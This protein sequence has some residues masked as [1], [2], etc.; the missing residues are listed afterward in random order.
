M[1]ISKRIII[2]LIAVLLL[3]IAFFISSN[4]NLPLKNINKRLKFSE[5]LLQQQEKHLNNSIQEIALYLKESDLNIQ[6]LLIKKNKEEFT[7]LIYIND[8]LKFWSKNTAPINE[9]AVK[10]ISRQGQLLKLKNGWYEAFY[11]EV[12]SLNKRKKIIG[13]FL[14]KSEYSYENKYLL[15]DFNP[16]L[17]IPKAFELLTYNQKNTYPLKSIK[18][19][20]LFYVKAD[21]GNNFTE[22]SNIILFLYLAGFSFLFLFIHHAAKYFVSKS[23]AKSL[24]LLG[25]L[26]LI[27]L[28][29]IY[30]KFP[31]ALYKLPLF[32]PQ[33]YASSFLLNSLGDLLINVLLVFYLTLFV[34]QYFHATSLA[35]K[36]KKNKT[37]IFLLVFLVLFLVYT[38]AA[39]NNYLLS[40]LIINSKISFNVINIFELNINSLVSFVIIGLLFFSFYLIVDAAVNFISYFN[41]SKKK[42]FLI[43]SVTASVF[44]FF[45]GGLKSLEIFKNYDLGAF[46]LASILVLLL[47]FYK[48]YSARPSTSAVFPFPK[49]LLI[50]LLFSIYSA[51]TL[52]NFNKRKEEENR[53]ILAER[54]ATEEDPIIEFLFEDI[55][56]SLS[57]D[58]IIHSL[59][60]ENADSSRFISA[61]I[62]NRLNLLY[63]TDYFEKYDISISCYSKSGELLYSSDKKNNSLSFYEANKL[64]G[65]KSAHSSNLFFFNGSLEDVAYLAFVGFN[66][67]SAFLSVKDS[68]ANS[69]QFNA[70]NSSVEKI[71]TIVIEFKLKFIQDEKDF[72]ELLL[73]QK[74]TSNRDFKNYSYARY[75]NKQLVYQY[76]NFSYPFFFQFSSL[77]KTEY[78]FVN[79]SNY[80]HLLYKTG[81]DSI[82]VISRKKENFL[83]TITLF[84]YLFTF[85]SILILAMFILR[86]IRS[87]WSSSYIIDFRTRVQLS[88]L[89]TVIGL[90]IVIG[91]LT[92]YNINKEYG[93]YHQERLIRKTRSVVQALQYEIE[94][95]PN[96]NL[97]NNEDLP[98]IINKLSL[99]H[100]I[101]INLY[102][103]NGKLIS[104][105]RSKIYERGLLSEMINPIAYNTLLKRQRTFFVHNENIARLNYLASY[106]PVRNRKNEFI[107][108]LNL[109]Y[110]TEE[111]NLKNEISSFLITW[112]NIY[113]P[114][115]VLVSLLAFLISRPITAPLSLIREK[116]RKIKLGE[117]NEPIEWER[118]DEIGELVNEY[119]RMMEE[120]DRNMKL[121]AK[122]ERELAWREMAKQVAHE[123]K[124][125]L[126]P[127]KLSIQHLQ[128]VGQNKTNNIHEMIERISQTLIQQI[129]T[130]SRI[131]EEFS[132]F[133][134]MPKAKYQEVNL[135][136]ILTNTISLFQGVENII[137]NYYYK[138]DNKTSAIVLADKDQLARAFNNII[139]NS[140][141]AIPL[142]KAGIIDIALYE[143]DES[144]LISIKDNGK[145]IIEEQRSKVFVPNFTTKSSGLGLGLAMVKNII[146]SCNGSIWLETSID[147]GTT[148]FI[149]LPKFKAM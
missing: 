56:H 40:D 132:N 12:D 148:F 111:D 52:I 100:D 15:N 25:C 76:G 62:I 113:V 77:L 42:Y 68:I 85:F 87:L 35:K 80:N 59:F 19:H 135:S 128:R 36:V 7:Y 22:Q 118:Q 107:A 123:I 122:S 138:I 5:Q 49:V 104:S 28:L 21:Q 131:A 30:F 78:H 47:I 14:I 134:Q 103:L 144:Y 70:N 72:S 130:L 50:I 79:R 89:V 6:N 8:T 137:I 2:L 41:I 110:L 120:L 33:Y 29:S 58:K 23:R 142:N 71:G 145:G 44:I 66:N 32:S 39:L 84:S 75:K 43:L 17:K 13:L 82:I 105:T 116:L 64:K 3:A 48:N 37:I 112:I 69:G 57:E 91:S 114:I 136:N 34:Y 65:E 1:L 149:S 81:S 139:K 102:N 129:D 119:N 109:P 96:K 127:M 93:T 73:S 46:L 115:F 106:T 67:Q 94:K 147:V 98:L 141:Q 20:I 143:E 124:N 95:Q 9:L 83:D 24:L 86:P 16:I 133:A 10:N 108:L 146:E 31:E 54:M 11:K 88:M 61:D 26:I 126:T 90:L 63:F 101:D 53:K 99:I 38:F 125:P 121:L 92:V 51:E 18:G 74:I 117:T 55:N 97:K 45:A 27:R 140:I 60:K 4:H